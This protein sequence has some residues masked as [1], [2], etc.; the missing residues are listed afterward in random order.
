MADKIILTYQANTDQFNKDIKKATQNVDGLDKATKDVNKTNKETFDSKGVKDYNKEVG[1]SSKGVGGLLGNLGKMVPVVGAAFSVGAVVGFVTELAAAGREV[2]KIQKGLKQLKGVSDSNLGPL[3]AQVQALASTFGEGEQEILQ[4]ANTLSKTFGI[5]GAEALKQI[6]R[7]YLSAANQNGDLLDSLKEYSVQVKDAGLGVEQFVNILDQSGQQGIFSDKGVDVIKEFGLRIREQSKATQDALNDAFGPKFTT[8]LFDGLNKGS[9]TSAQ[10]LERVSKK[11]KESQLPAKQLQTVVADVFGGPGED[12]GLDFLKTLTDITAEN[13]TIVNEADAYTKEQ[14]RQIEVQAKFNEILNSVKLVALEIVQFV[15][16]GVVA[17]FELVE[18]L[19]GLNEIKAALKSIEDI[20]SAFE[21]RNKL[22]KEF[23]DLAKESNEDLKNSVAQINEQFKQGLINGQQYN[24]LLAEATRQSNEQLASQGAIN[25]QFD[26]LSKQAE[27][28]KIDVDSI[29]AG[30]G[31]TEEGVKILKEAIGGAAFEEKKRADLLKK[32]QAEQKK[33]ADQQ[34]KAAE[35]REKQIQRETER[36]REQAQDLLLGEEG[37]IERINN[38]RAKQLEDL[39]QNK[40]FERLTIQEQNALIKNIEKESAD[41]ITAIKEEQENKEKAILDRR[42]QAEIE[43]VKLL[44]GGN[45]EA[46]VEALEKERDFLLENDELLSEEKL[47]IEAQFQEQI[48]Q[49]RDQGAEEE[50]Q[51][52][53]AQ[54]QAELDLAQV[55]IDSA[56]NV[57]GFLQTVVDENTALG[58]TL[59]LTEKALAIAE[60]FINLQREISSIAATNAALGPAGVPLTVAQ[61]TAAKIRAATGIA[62][63]VATTVQGFKDGVIDLAGPGTTTSDS[64]PAKLSKG[65]SVMTAKETRKYKDELQAIRNN[66]FEDFVLDKYITPYLSGKLSEIEKLK[67]G[68]D[69]PK[70]DN[71]LANGLLNKLVKGQSKPIELGIDTISK[72]NSSNRRSFY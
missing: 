46:Q 59:F 55:R 22:E 15:R 20:N 28:Y 34:R 38:L 37:T 70:V 23:K 31:K 30:Y 48:K 68:V 16:E 25:K 66:Q 64:I 65:E 19:S 42:K 45:I 24:E 12:V 14:Q 60:I 6:E 62:T 21:E 2:L 33:L 63:I 52:L 51:R 8:E 27:K 1:N 18:E 29:V 53:E 7:G 40:A 54:A 11:L 43:R 36:L 41:Q 10:A 72:L 5:D 56:K 9:I 3:T 50:K 35:E 32:Q 71:K 39:R 17:A 4:A 61:T 58:K 44:A 47:L 69:S 67:A 13:K 49:L 57:L 26:D